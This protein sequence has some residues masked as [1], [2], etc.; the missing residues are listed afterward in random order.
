MSSRIFSAGVAMGLGILT[1]MACVA[2]LLASSIVE[3]CSL[4]ER[5][6]IVVDVT[7]AGACIT[8]E[9]LVQGVT[10]PLVILASCAGTTVE[11]ILAVLAT[12][13]EVELDAGT[14]AGAA[15]G[16]RLEAVRQSALALRAPPP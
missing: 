1:C 10:D 14:D 16:A 2:S 5:R 3:G 15:L 12:L 9:L 7:P 8:S 11:S 4:A 6:A 13:E